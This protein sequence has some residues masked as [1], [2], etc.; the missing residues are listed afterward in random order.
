MPERDNFNQFMEINKT[1][2][3]LTEIV[4]RHDK[5]TFPEITNALK[6]IESKHNQDYLQYVEAKEEAKR[7]L[8]NHEERLRKVEK[9]N[10]EAKAEKSKWFSDVSKHTVTAIITFLTALFAIN[11][12]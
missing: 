2:G 11:N 10:T 9:I 3:R 4:E 5:V 12:K 1:L 7:L 6:R 8:E